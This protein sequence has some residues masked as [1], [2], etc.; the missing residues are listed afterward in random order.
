[1]HPLLTEAVIA[2]RLTLN[3]VV[4]QEFGHLLGLLNHRLDRGVV[5][6]KGRLLAEVVADLLP[7][8]SEHGSIA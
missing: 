4:P 3:K 2:L 5:G 7:S 6:G 8:C 1:M